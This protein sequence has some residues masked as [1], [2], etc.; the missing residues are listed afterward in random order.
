MRDVVFDADA[1]RRLM[2]QLDYLLSIGATKAAVDL[3][4]RV[5]VFITETLATFPAIGKPL[6]HRGLWETW[7]PGTRIVVWYRHSD[8]TLEIVDV[9]ST[10]QDRTKK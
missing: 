2:A 9:W 6:A 1:E 3:E 5:R 4:S 8:A 7:I 10:W